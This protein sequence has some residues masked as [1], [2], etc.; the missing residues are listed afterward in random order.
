MKAYTIVEPTKRKPRALRSSDSAS[1]TGVVA[2]M[3][4]DR[5]VGGRRAG[6]PRHDRREIAR[7]TS[8]TPRAVARNAGRVADGRI[9]LRAVADDP[10]VGHQPSPVALVERGHRRAGRTRRRR[11]GTP[12]ACAGSSTTTGPPGTTRARAARTARRRRGPACPIRRRGRR[13]SA[14]PGRAVGAG[15]GAARSRRPPWA[16]RYRAS[17]DRRGRDERAAHHRVGRR[18]LRVEDRPEDVARHLLRAGRCR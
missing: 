13:P 17:G 18:A 16:P 8:R 4:P 6:G 11:P 2:G 9:D 15:P 1:E 5:A 14:G 7:R 3:P 10:G 12:R